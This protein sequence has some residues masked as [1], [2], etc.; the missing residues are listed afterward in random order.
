MNSDENGSVGSWIA[1]GDFRLDTVQRR[2]WRSDGTPVALSARLFDALAF[3]VEHAGELLDK[4]RLLSA[5]WPGQVV[6]ENNLNQTVSALRRALGD[7]GDAHR[8]LLTLPR[9]GFRFVAAV[10]TVA[11]DDPSSRSGDPVGTAPLHATAADRPR[12]PADT[13]VTGRG[14]RV[15]ITGG[16]AVVVLGAGAIAWQRHRESQTGAETQ[17]STTLAVL[18]SGC[19]AARDAMR[20][21]NSAWPTA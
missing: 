5:L 6:E 9:R 7:D 10:R 18:H 3:F 15:L 8:Y 13:A 17:P 21:W 2:L 1:F 19:S 12:A 4:E 14:R 16:V 11:A 20:C